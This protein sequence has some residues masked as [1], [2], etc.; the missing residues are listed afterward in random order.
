MPR[1]K[2]VESGV[3]CI[4]FKRYPF[5][6]VERRG[7]AIGKKETRVNLLSRDLLQLVDRP[8]AT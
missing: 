4:Q 5:L 6:W 2:Q 3:G 7:V 1:M 8:A